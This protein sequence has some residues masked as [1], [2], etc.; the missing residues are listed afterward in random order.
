MDNQCMNESLRVL[1]ADDDPLNLRVAARLLKEM[2]HNG[3]LVT[4]GV[5]VMRIL[6]QQDFDLLLLDMSMPNMDGSETLKAI[7]SRERQGRPRLPVLMVTGYDDQNTRQ[8]L[9][10][11][12]ADDVLAK[13]LSIQALQAALQR[14][15]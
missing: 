4:D 1:V 6:E 14:L 15:V 13:P 7:R 9:M 11:D 8:R 10:S 3:A 5:Q 2:G 12:G